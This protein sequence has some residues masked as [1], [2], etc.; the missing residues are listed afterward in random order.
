MVIVFLPHLA[1]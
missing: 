1:I